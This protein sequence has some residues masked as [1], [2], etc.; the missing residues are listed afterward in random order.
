MRKKYLISLFLI[1]SII[2][3]VDIQAINKIKVI[4]IGGGGKLINAGNDRDNP[5]KLVDRTIEYFTREFNKVM[6]YKPDLILLSEACERPAGLNSKEEFEYY[7]VRGNQIQDYFASVAKQNRCYIAFGMKHEENGNWWNSCVV[8]DREGKVAGI[9]HKNY[10]TVYEMPV[11][12]PGTEIPLIK[13]DFGSV[14]C[15]ICFDLNFDELRDKFAALKPDIILFP[16]NY[17]GGLEQAKWAYS[18]RSFFVCSY[19]FLTAPSEIRDP[20]GMVV[21]T[22]TNQNNY[23]VAT[24]NLDRKMVHLDFNREKITA[25]QKKYGN[26]VV[27]TD[28]GLMGVAIISSEHEQISA[29]EMIKEFNIE[30]L[31]DYFDRSRQDIQK[32]LRTK[33]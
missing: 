11:I 20:F 1:V 22:S 3:C 24:I 8:L 16:S 6:L 5:Q 15:A 31:D 2:Y 17:H 10:P 14:A 19:G 27:Y 23:A 7:R 32:N 26:K 12:S 18:C 30:L 13:C 4:T 25:L 21:A 9:Y 33:Q 28:P 29:A